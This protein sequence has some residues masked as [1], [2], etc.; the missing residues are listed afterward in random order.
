LGAGFNF[1]RSG[2]YFWPFL[3]RQSHCHD[4]AWRRIHSPHHDD[5]FAVIFG[6]VV[7]GIASIPDMKK[8][9]RVGGEALLYFEGTSTSALFIGLFVGNLN[10]ST[11]AVGYFPLET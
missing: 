7:S 3:S 4:A 8:V 6:T 2:R 10:F 1:E 5:H 9:G 11:Y